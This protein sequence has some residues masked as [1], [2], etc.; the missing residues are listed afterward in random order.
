MTVERD[1]FTSRMQ[2]A[3]EPVDK[4]VTNLKSLAKSCVYGTLQDYLIKDP[5]VRGVNSVGL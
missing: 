3:N 1:R 2:G 5:I 4:W